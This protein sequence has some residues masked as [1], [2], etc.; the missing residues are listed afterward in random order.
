MENSKIQKVLV[1]NDKTA[2]SNG[3][4]MYNDVFLISLLVTIILVAT[5][6]TIVLALCVGDVA[7][8]I[9]V[10][11]MLFFLPAFSIGVATRFWERRRIYCFEGNRIYTMRLNSEYVFEKDKEDRKVDDLAYFSMYVKKIIS[12][13]NENPNCRSFNNS[14]VSAIK[15]YDDVE[16][17]KETSRYDLYQGADSNGRLKKFKIVHIYK[18]YTL[19]ESDEFSLDMP[20]YDYV[21]ESTDEPRDSK[22]CWIMTGVAV[23]FLI[24]LLTTGSIIMGEFAAALSVVGI[25]WGTSRKKELS[26]EEITTKDTLQIVVSWIALVITAVLLLYAIAQNND[27]FEISRLRE[28]SKS[29]DEIEQE[30][31]DYDEKNKLS[32]KYNEEVAEWVNSSSDMEFEFLSTLEDPSSYTPDEN[33]VIQVYSEN[34]EMYAL[35]DHYPDEDDEYRLVAIYVAP[36]TSGNVFGFM[37]GDSFDDCVGFLLDNGFSV[38][39]DVDQF[40]RIHLENGDVL[41]RVYGGDNGKINTILITSAHWYYGSL[42]RYKEY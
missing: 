34:E 40:G 15:V 3:F 25:M 38:Y 36:E 28:L 30:F 24:F 31:D 20:E 22:Q 23:L 7:M 10:L 27:L 42:Q 2:K 33:G 39:L 12:R 41:V 9:C 6:V 16:L 11:A 29:Y 32:V 19:V 5:I 4:I 21:L 1:F 8:V 37:K 14:E 13:I 26:A 18:A 17:I 35:Y